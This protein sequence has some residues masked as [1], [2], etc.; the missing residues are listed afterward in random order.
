MPNDYAPSPVIPGHITEPSDGDPENAASVDGALEALADGEAYLLN[1]GDKQLQAH[2][3]NSNGSVITPAWLTSSFAYN[4]DDA[5]CKL[6]FANAKQN[7]LIKIDFSAYATTTETLG[8]NSH[9]AVF[10]SENGG[11]FT[12]VDGAGMAMPGGGGAVAM[13]FTGLYQVVNDGTVVLKL[14]GRNDTTGKS[15]AIGFY[16]VFRGERVRP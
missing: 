10:A 2:A 14:Y 1:K 13:C 7:D 4:G 8:N 9:L 11:S 5:H 15:L 3:D 6:T 16:F 12:Q